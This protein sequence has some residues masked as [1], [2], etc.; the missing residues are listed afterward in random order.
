[1]KEVLPVL[2][3]SF[4][5]SGILTWAIPLAVLLLVGGYW[6]FALRRHP[7]ELE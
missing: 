2:L 1:M 7:D 6:W 3:A 4:L 5:T